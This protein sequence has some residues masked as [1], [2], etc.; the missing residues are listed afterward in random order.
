M[1]ELFVLE[2]DQS[3][4]K[5]RHL[6][7]PSGMKWGNE[8]LKAES[9][10]DREPGQLYVSFESDQIDL[11]D[12]F[13]VNGT[14]V[15]KEK[16]L[17]K[18]LSLASSDVEP[19]ATQIRFR[20]GELSGYWLINVSSQCN[21]IDRETSEFSKFGPVIA[22]IFDLHLIRNAGVFPHLFRDP[23]YLD[24]LFA[25]GEMVAKLNAGRFSGLEIRK[26][27][28]WNDGHRF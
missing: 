14:P 19:I 10:M 12:F 11:P 9:T 18:L 25:S 27:Q 17:Q 13:E 21:A 24:I 16:M 6:T 4:R 7:Q 8:F 5:I 2:S 1:Q 23:A 26:A 3:V 20:N 28:G 22:R 15:V